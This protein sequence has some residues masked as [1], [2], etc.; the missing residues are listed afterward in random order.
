MWNSDNWIFSIN[1]NQLVLFPS[2]LEHSVPK[3]KKASADRI[4]ISFNTFVRGNLG[5]RD[6]LT[7]LIL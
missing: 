2:W 3:N 5:K 7:E 4:S 1:N 6:T